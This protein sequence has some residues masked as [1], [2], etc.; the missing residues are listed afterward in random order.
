MKVS[1]FRS[2]LDLSWQNIL[3][4]IIAVLSL[5]K[6]LNIIKAL[7]FSSKKLDEIYLLSFLK[8]VLMLVFY[9]VDF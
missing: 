5:H 9:Y 2:V 6:M 1:G 4:L 8:N 3:D 7:M